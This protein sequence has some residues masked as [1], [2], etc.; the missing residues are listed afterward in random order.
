MRVKI[1]RVGGKRPVVRVQLLH[2]N[3]S[4]SVEVEEQQAMA[5]GGHLYR[6]ADLTLSVLRGADGKRL[7]S[8]L[9]EFQAVSD[10]DP[11][12][13]W[14]RWFQPHA[15][16]WEGIPDIEETLRNRDRS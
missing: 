4:F 11:G 16:Y 14:R 13:A 8:Y 5:L 6:E 9:K 7:V 2:E 1:V 3:E 15:D 10:E 12:E